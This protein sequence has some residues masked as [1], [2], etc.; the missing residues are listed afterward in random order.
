MIIKVQ[1]EQS[2]EK[3][4]RLSIAV[5][6]ILGMF[7]YF[8][9]HIVN[10]T[11]EDNIAFE[12]KLETIDKNKIEARKLSRAI[13][14]ESEN[15]ISLVGANHIESIKLTKQHLTIFLTKQEGVKRL[16]LR[17]DSLAST[18][19]TNGLWKVSLDIKKLLTIKRDENLK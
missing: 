16:S 12:K 11:E 17:Y 18:Q 7:S 5:L 15:I 3:I 2:S 14:N 4:L 19:K 1:R 6:I 9:F 8:Y 10:K 13:L